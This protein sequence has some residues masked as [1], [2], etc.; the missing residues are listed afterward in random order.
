VPPSA[1]DLALARELHRRGRL[2]EATLKA[3]LSEVTPGRSL[4]VVLVAR[5]LVTPEELSLGDSRGVAPTRDDTART[6]APERAD[7]RTR[8]GDMTHLSSAG[9]QRTHAGDMTHLSSDQRTHAGDMTHLSSDP[10]THAGDVTRL[11]ND[12]DPRTHAAPDRPDPNRTF[13]ADLANMPQRARADSGRQTWM[14]FGEEAPALAV[15][16]PTGTPPQAVDWKVG[17]RVGRYR[18]DKELGRGGMG[19][20][21]LGTDEEGGR[22]VA[23]KTLLPNAS[24]TAAKRFLREGEAQAAVDEH[25]NVLRVHAAGEAGGR[26]YLVMD[27]ATGGDLAG[28]LKQ[29]PLPP[30]EAARLIRD[31]TRGLAHVHARGVIH[32]DLKPANVLFDESGTPKLVDFGLA[33]VEGAERLTATGAFMGTPAYMAPE[34]TGGERVGEPADIYSMGAMLYHMLV[35]RSPFEGEAGTAMIAKLLT[36][37][38]QPPRELVPDVPES[39]ERVVLKCLAKKPH[40]RYASATALAADLERALAGHSVE[41]PRAPSKKPLAAAGVGIALGLVVCAVALVTSLPKAPAATVTTT[42]AVAIVPSAAEPVDPLRSPTFGLPTTRRTYR[43]Q[44]YTMSGSPGLLTFRATLTLGPAVVG[45]DGAVMCEGTLSDLT[46][47]GGTINSSG[48]GDL[49]HDYGADVNEKLIVAVSATGDL[50]VSCLTAE[51]RARLWELLPGPVRVNPVNPD[52]VWPGY[53]VRALL[54]DELLADVLQLSLPLTARDERGVAVAGTP[55]S[56]GRGAGPS[57]LFTRE[58]HGVAELTSIEDQVGPRR[59]RVPGL[60][61][62]HRAGRPPAVEGQPRRGLVGDRPA[63]R[64]PQARADPVGAR[65]GAADRGLRG[66]G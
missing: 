64:V 4:A 17:G 15:P 50:S 26:Q 6:R 51:V 54:K 44:W 41:A 14:P 20:V 57:I 7:P 22:R 63:R 2:P 33:A 5:R 25:A 52:G 49:E 59:R 12:G 31:L 27:F 35:G 65:G 39:L 24:P 11:S 37:P 45:P 10:R 60:V 34:Q 62:L 30:L 61:H 56:Y 21:Y 19:V 23:I 18:L 47:W 43:C 55:L 42:E 13:S 48:L 3:A 53:L 46:V 66:P 1:A 58:H 8:P 38:P 40:Q 29:G 28:R 9:D 32:R 16:T 36:Q